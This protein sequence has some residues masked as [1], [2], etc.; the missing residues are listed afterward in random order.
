[1]QLLLDRQ[2]PLRLR[3]T[4]TLPTIERGSSAQPAELL[5][6][7]LRG[8]GPTAQ[9]HQFALSGELVQA[10]LWSRQRWT[11][12]MP[13]TRIRGARASAYGVCVKVHNPILLKV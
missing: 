13:F 10:L 12:P 3:P 8:A 9:R 2:L 7:D 11:R 5:R 4:E 1:M 6:R